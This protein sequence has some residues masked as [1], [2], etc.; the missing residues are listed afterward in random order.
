[1]TFADNQ[2]YWNGS[3]Q[4]AG[5]VRVREC[6]EGITTLL[7]SHIT[8]QDTTDSRPP[9]STADHSPGQRVT[10]PFAQINDAQ[11]HDPNPLIDEFHGP[12]VSPQPFSYMPVPHSRSLF[13]PHPDPIADA[14]ERIGP[15]RDPEISS[16]QG[17]RNRGTGS[18]G[19]PY[20]NC[21]KGYGRP[22]DLKRHIR[23]KHRIPPRCPFCG[24]ESTRAENIRKH[25]I[26]QHGDRFSSEE[27]RDIC[28]LQGWEATIGFLEK[29]RTA[30]RTERSRYH[31]QARRT[32]RWE[33]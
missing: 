10:F 6:R 26:V 19:C 14:L 29:C 11:F 3:Q 25:L 4:L 20:V 21:D 7:T 1:M 32:L 12:H 30:P 24:I 2:T 18:K 5:Q 28:R 8:D 22:Q 27:R 13:Q 23:D 33:A 15:Q 17:P 31:E 16:V 9:T